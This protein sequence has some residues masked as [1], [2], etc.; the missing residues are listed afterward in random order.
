M[1]AL[2][3]LRPTRR[4]LGAAAVVGLALAL[5]SAFG[6]RSLGAVV[7]PGASALLIGAVQTL[8]ADAPKVDRASIDAGFPGDRRT[9]RVT[10]ESSAP[11]TVVEPVGDG[12][13]VPEGTTN[14][15]TEAIGHGG[16]FEYTVELDRRGEHRV[17]PA[18]C[19]ISD[20]F[21]LF[22][23]VTGEEEA[24]TVLVYP[25]VYDVEARALSRLTSGGGGTD[26]SMFERLREYTTE[27]TMGDIHWRASAK[28]PDEEFLVA[29]YGG[30][31]TR[32]RVMIV[33]ESDSDDADA[34]ASAVTSLLTR[35]DAMGRTATVVV[36]DGECTSRPGGSVTA[37]RLLARTGG[38]TVAAGERD[39]AD[40]YVRGQGDDVTATVAGR[41]LEIG[42]ERDSNRQERT[43]S[44]APTET[45]TIA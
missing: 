1:A 15:V 26:R 21:G 24:E 7:V 3:Q 8:R 38:G 28:R 43:E 4:G 6:M 33:G 31:T 10:V 14:P 35:L 19:R 25:T 29:E 5:G 40:V 27:D 17:G 41:R 39:R 11:C 20:S 32:D 45:G 23:A 42:P 37:L 2:R 44:I 36:A 22:S 12:L 30:R 34:M 13:A 18:R 9:V 16:Q